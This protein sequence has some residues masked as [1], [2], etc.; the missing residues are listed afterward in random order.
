[1]RLIT[2]DRL[3]SRPALFRRAQRQPPVFVRC[4]P[5]QT[6]DA[7][8]VMHLCAHPARVEQRVERNPFRPV[9][10]VLAKHRDA[11]Q[12]SGVAQPGTDGD[13]FQFI[14]VIAPIIELHA[15]R[16]HQAQQRKCNIHVPRRVSVV[17]INR[18]AEINRLQ[19]IG[20]STNNLVARQHIVAR[21]AHRTQ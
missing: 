12:F 11:G 10:Q 7:G 14:R 16:A 6:F 2:A 21:S 15:C 1:L 3:I 9:E 20:D 8:I 5:F 13:M 18:Q 4:N 19:A 17:G